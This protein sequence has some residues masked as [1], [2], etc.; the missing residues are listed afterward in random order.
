MLATDI[1][2]GLLA[3][4]MSAIVLIGAVQLWML[5]GFALG[6]GTIA[7]FAIPAQNSIVPTLVRR[8]DLQVGNA[9]IMGATQ[10]T[11]FVGPTLA[12]AIIAA[13]SSASIGVGL[14]FGID[15]I[16]F[17]VSATTFAL[18]RP[19]GAAIDDDG[20]VSLWASI[21]DGVDRLRN[22]VPLRFVF[23][24]LAAV[25]L[26][27]VGPLLIGIPLLAHQ[28]LAEGAMAF[29]VLMAAFA[30]GNLAG[31]VLVAT[32]KTP[33]STAMR[34]IV[35]AV[36][37]GHG[38]AIAALAAV[39]DT[40]IGAALLACLG[41]G[42]GYL[43]ITLFT[44]MQARTPRE[45]LGRTMS[46]LTFASLGLVSVS[47]AAAGALG[48][49]D[50]DSLFLLSGGLVLATTVWAASNPGLRAFTDSVSDSRQP[51][52]QSPFDQSPYNMEH[53]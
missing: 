22:D 32:A 5:Y 27:A 18:M 6:F 16:T 45:L 17:A 44:W 9:I 20:S 37:G 14:A 40:A 23:C 12:G 10:L 36:V 52:D 39:T 26:F 24:V 31:Y 38:I 8:D 25:N 11:A 21:T 15:A 47:Q 19:T 30:V 41:L 28:R 50:L 46:L 49:R 35:L 7:G 2:R 4:A 53:P 3:G 13:Y 43:A 34:T 1:A 33:S 48:K 42:N 29:G 51:D